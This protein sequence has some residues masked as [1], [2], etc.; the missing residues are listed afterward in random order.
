ME[1]RCWDIAH[2][3]GL[4]VENPFKTAAIYLFIVKGN[5]ILCGSEILLEPIKVWPESF[6]ANIN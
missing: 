6:A 5:R 2:I 3:F 4:M 1:L